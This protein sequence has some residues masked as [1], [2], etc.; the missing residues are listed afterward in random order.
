MAQVHLRRLADALLGTLLAVAAACTDAGDI[1]PDMT[2]EHLDVWLDEGIEACAGQLPAYDRFADR[3]LS[4]WGDASPAEF[5]AELHVVTEERL[6]SE[7][8]CSEDS[9]ACARSGTVWTSDAYAIH[10]EL[11]HV[12]TGLGSAPWAS[13][14]VAVAF[15]N[16]WV[17][18]PDLDEFDI[19]AS[20]STALGWQGYLHAGTFTRYLIEEHGADAMRRYHDA[21]RKG[22]PASEL[23]SEFALAFGMPLD[24]ALQ[25]YA[26]ADFG[27]EPQPRC[28]FQ[29]STC[30]D[31]DP[32]DLPFLIEGSLDCQSPNVRGFLG[33]DPGTSAFP[34][35]AP[36]RVVK[37]D[38]Q[39][40][41]GAVDDGGPYPPDRYVWISID[42]RDATVE[43]IRCGTCD[44]QFGDFPYDGPTNIEEELYSEFPLAVGSYTFVVSPLSGGP[45]LFELR[46]IEPPA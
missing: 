18:I 38:L 39:P 10:H 42:V 45:M 16:G 15:G 8:L 5:R 31:A 35:F 44:E 22:D 23:E 41:P 25:G 6:H 46:R 1:P 12:M 2:S 32:V 34:P 14:G 26:P 19:F 33:P 13:E 17:T 29:L 24:D 21:A 11:V 20:A 28:T 36:Q 30:D 9:R 40:D 3:F 43:M 37:V 27:G 7:Q 4:V